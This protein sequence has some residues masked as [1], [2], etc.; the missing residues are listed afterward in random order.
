MH[1]PNTSVSIVVPTCNERE[2]ISDLLERIQ[3]SMEPLQDPFEILIVDD[4]S[5]DE[6]WKV[7]SSYSDRYPVRVLR[8]E[9]KRG[10]APSVLDG[11]RASKHDIVVVVDA[12]LQ[13]APEAIPK[14]VS[15]V[16]D[17]TDIAI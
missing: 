2:N 16:R 3:R 1:N 10:R 9:G 7:A 5:P 15:E 17:G 8:R 4:D 11:I 6:T 14:L 12:D 13:H